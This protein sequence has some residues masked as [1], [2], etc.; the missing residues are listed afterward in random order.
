[1][2]IQA[3]SDSHLETRTN[4]KYTHIQ[5]YQLYKFYKHPVLTIDVVNDYFKS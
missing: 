5:I 2:K 4:P 1:M 3:R